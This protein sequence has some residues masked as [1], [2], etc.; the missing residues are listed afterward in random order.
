M[1]LR[2]LPENTL[3]GIKVVVGPLQ[4]HGWRFRVGQTRCLNG[5]FNSCDFEHFSCLIW[6]ARKLNWYWLALLLFQW[7]VYSTTK[8]LSRVHWFLTTTPGTTSTHQE[9]I[10]CSWFFRFDRLF[11]II[12]INFFIRRPQELLPVLGLLERWCDTYTWRGPAV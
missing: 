9:F 2:N 12:N 5:M 8:R 10:L 1:Q 4:P 3:E 7:S 6:T 11:G